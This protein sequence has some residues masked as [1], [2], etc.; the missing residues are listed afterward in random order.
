MTEPIVFEI[1][2]TGHFDATTPLT[3]TRD[4]FTETGKRYYQK[5]LT[6]AAGVISGDFFGLFQSHAVKLVGVSG[7]SHNPQSL[8]RVVTPYGAG[9]VRSVLQLAPEVR[10]LVMMPND[11]LV[12]STN[13]TTETTQILLVVNEMSEADHVRFAA[14]RPAIL[15]PKLSRNAGGRRFT[16]YHAGGDSF[17][18]SATTWSPTF[19]FDGTSGKLTSTSVQT[20]SIPCSVLSRRALHH[21]IYVRVRFAGTTPTSGT[22]YLFDGESGLGRT[23]EAS[24]PPMKWSKVLT[25]GFDD[26]I[27]F[28]GAS[29]AGSPIAVDIDVVDALPGEHLSRLWEA[30]L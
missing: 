18:A 6:A 5:D 19:T 28:A 22:V 1:N 11:K 17:V 15:P 2:K 14:P 4:D 30:D 12:L 23:V 24:I 21:T 13:E 29:A 16:V 9:K 3:L 26:K 27:G 25:M 7:V 10:Y 20:G 8:A